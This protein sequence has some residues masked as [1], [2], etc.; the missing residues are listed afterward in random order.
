MD[1]GGNQRRMAHDQRVLVLKHNGRGRQSTSEWVVVS[2]STP[3]D[4]LAQAVLSS[5]KGEPR[6]LRAFVPI[7][8]GAVSR[9]CAGE[10]VSAIMQRAFG[11]A[12][13]RNGGT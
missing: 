4:R 6:F 13:K 7:R 3:N 12:K 8:G 10:D 11:R 2:D 1:S 9:A 5:G